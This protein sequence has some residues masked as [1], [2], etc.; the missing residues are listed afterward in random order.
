MVTSVVVRAFDDPPI[1]SFQLS[2]GTPYGNESYWRA[3]ERFHEFLP[4]FNGAGGSMYYYMLPNFTDP[5]LGHLSVLS[6]FGGFAN[7]S[8]ASQADHIMKPLVADLGRIMG[9]PLSYNSTSYR[10]SS[11]LFT[12]F[13]SDPG[14]AGG[15]AILG[16]R[17]MTR[18]FLSTASG[19][20]KLV[21][22]L[23]SLRADHTTQF[24]GLVVAGGQA[25]ANA[26]K[27]HSA[28][29]P[30][31]RRALVEVIIPR[32][33][34]P[35][36]PIPVQ[37]AIQRN[38]TEVEV[39]ILKALDPSEGGGTYLNEADGYELDFQD[40]FWGE[41]YPKLYQ[42][43]QKWDPH[44]LFIVRSGVGSEDWDDEGMCRK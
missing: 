15:S 25:A 23:R 16:S 22:A 11:S 35:T 28:L 1:V 21:S 41:N 6:A 8:D 18:D 30:V 13:F 19:P 29:H 2:G 12:A 9:F 31:W 5:S 26:D 44:N 24:Q 17:I 36:T 4:R 40:S 32:G 38:L 7:Y 39:P 37:Q 42:L 3:L 33:W 10:K 14:N 20:K 34:L 27:V 43:K